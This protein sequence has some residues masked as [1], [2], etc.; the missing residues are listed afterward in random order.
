M[1]HWHCE[2]CEK[3]M[4]MSSRSR[5]LQSR[6]HLEN[7]QRSQIVSPV[8]SVSIHWHCEICDKDMLY[9]SRAKH[10]ESARHIL[11]TRNQNP[12]QVQEPAPTHWHCQVCDKNMKVSSRSSHLT[13]K[14]HYSKV[15]GGVVPKNKECEICYEP[16]AFNRFKSCRRC[17]NNW[18]GKCHTQMGRCPFCRTN[19][20]RTYDYIHLGLY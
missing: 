5:H 1:S 6:R 17:N 13:S 2:V 3:D 12:P 9:S 19:F 15:H 8:P 11:R 14:S 4:K 7:V 10:L 18:C 20:S 16:S